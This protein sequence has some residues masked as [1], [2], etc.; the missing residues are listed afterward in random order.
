[1][2][3]HDPST[4]E[5]GRAILDASTRTEPVTP[6]PGAT[7]TPEQIR[8]ELLAEAD[9]LEAIA[10]QMSFHVDGAGPAWADSRHELCGGADWCRRRA[11]LIQ[12]S[13]P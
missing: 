10:L 12:D 5:V 1:M 13:M 11:Q 9:R 6:A 2:P 7:W 8:R 4:S 3:E